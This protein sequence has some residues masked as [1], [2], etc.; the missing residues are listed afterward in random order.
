MTKSTIADL[1][2][3]TQGERCKSFWEHLIYMV[4]VAESHV[5]EAGWALWFPNVRISPSRAALPDDAN[6]QTFDRLDWDGQTLDG[7]A[8]DCARRRTYRNRP[9]CS[10]ALIMAACRPS[11]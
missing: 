11:R 6:Q 8:H 7:T 10:R 1:I 5:E 4:A 3:E 2:D 9:R